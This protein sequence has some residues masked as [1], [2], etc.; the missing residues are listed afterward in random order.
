M[1]KTET[2]TFTDSN[3]KTVTHSYKTPEALVDGVKKELR[4]INI[5]RIAT[6][7]ARTRERLNKASC[8]LL[9][10]LADIC[11]PFSGRQIGGHYN[12]E[13]R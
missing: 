3:L 2:I 9:I 6:T 12:T 10:A 13:L 5:K 8:D 1:K 11:A 7:S 4:R